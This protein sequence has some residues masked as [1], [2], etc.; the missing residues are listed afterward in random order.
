MRS[1]P[2]PKNARVWDPCVI[3]DYLAGKQN[4]AAEARPI[5]EAAKRGQTQIWVS[6]FAE[7]EVAYLAGM[8]DEQSERVIT[9]FFEQDYIV[10]V[11]VDPFVSESARQLIRATHISGKDAVHVATAIRWEVPIFETFDEKL[12]KKLEPFRADPVLTR[13]SCRL[14]LFEGQRTFDD[15]VS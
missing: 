11:S 10:R 4:A 7:V 6:T 8:T 5:V 9:E 3:T 1:R 15:S 2:D 13:V 14:P 12:L